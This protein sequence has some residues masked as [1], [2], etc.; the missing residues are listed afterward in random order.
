MS[1]NIQIP[2]IERITFVSGQRLLAR[3]MTALDE[4]HR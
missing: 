2:D 4:S 3:D 1:D